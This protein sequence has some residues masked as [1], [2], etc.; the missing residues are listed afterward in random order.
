MI[1]NPPKDLDCPHLCCRSCIERIAGGRKI[2]ECPE[3]RK[4]T[5]IPQGGVVAMRTNLRVKNLALKHAAYQQNRAVA[6]PKCQRH[7]PELK[8]F[9]C[10]TCNTTACQVCVRIAHESCDIK[11]LRGTYEMQTDEMTTTLDEMEAEAQLITESAENLLELKQNIEQSL[12]FEQQKIDKQEELAVENIRKAAQAQRAQ[13]RKTEAQRLGNI[14]KETARLKKQADDIREMNEKAD[15]VVQEATNHEYVTQ[16]DEL[17]KKL[18]GMLGVDKGLGIDRQVDRTQFAV[19]S[20]LPSVPLGK[21]VEF[22]KLSMVQKF[23]KFDTLVSITATPQGSLVLLDKDSEQEQLHVYHPVDDGTYTLQQSL[24]LEASSTF[25]PSGVAVMNDGR[26]L[27]ARGTQIEV[28]MSGGS[29]E[30][31]VDLKTGKAHVIK[32]KEGGVIIADTEKS[33]V[34]VLSED[35]ST[36]ISTFKTRI[37]PRCVAVLPNDCIAISNF[38]SPEV[39]VANLTSGEVV[40]SYDIPNALA[41]CYHDATDSILVGRCKK[42]LS[43][44]SLPLFGMGEIEQYC[45]TT[46]SMVGKCVDVKLDCPWDMVLTQSG[47]LAVADLWTAKIFI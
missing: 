7:A 9:Y 1:T 29:Y 46:G 23:G 33:K 28:Y 16:H 36:T 10:A 21:V 15:K 43:D 12:S 3:C 27:V 11:E 26:F 6:P 4:M 32:I 41:L 5:C 19:G 13:L 38:Q 37:T 40:Q 42:L 45:C 44:K 14:Q 18:K 39:M 2:I 34:T 24:A 25:K 20:V 8:H 31:S 47:E 22:R 30:H 17:A 35:L